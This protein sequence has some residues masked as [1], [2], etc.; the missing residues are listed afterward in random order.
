[1]YPLLSVFGVVL[2]SVAALV[3]CFFGFSWL[4]K[5]FGQEKVE[6]YVKMRTQGPFVPTPKKESEGDK[7]QH[8]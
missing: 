3:V 7:I 8:G 6:G 1:M 2:A 4:V 5:L